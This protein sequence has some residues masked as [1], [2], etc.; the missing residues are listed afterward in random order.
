M[1]LIRRGSLRE[2]RKIVDKGGDD[3]DETEAQTWLTGLRNRPG[4]VLPT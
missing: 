3:D 1:C 4:E 2:R